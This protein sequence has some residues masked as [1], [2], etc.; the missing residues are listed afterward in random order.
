MRGIIFDAG[1]V[2]VTLDGAPGLSRL[3]GEPL[4]VDDFH[5]RWLVCPSVVLHE[6]G[7][8]SAEQFAENIVIELG[9]KVS[10]SAFLADFATWFG[11]V[12]PEA[13]QLVE[14]IPNRYKVAILSNMSALHWRMV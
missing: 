13:L 7:R 11:G 8:M 1:G 12:I 14:R 2:L 3:L 6:T 10:P 4:S 5:R 9:L